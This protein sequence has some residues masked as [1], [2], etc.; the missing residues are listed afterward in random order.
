MWVNMPARKNDPL[1]PSGTVKCLT[2]VRAS[3]SVLTFQS[4]SAII[5]I[6]LS[7]AIRIYIT[8]MKRHHEAKKPLKRV[9]LQTITVPD[10]YY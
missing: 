9:L 7:D 6:Q 1:Q 8:R 2:F 3:L 10:N 4:V 5:G